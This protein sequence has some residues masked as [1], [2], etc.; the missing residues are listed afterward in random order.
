MS[1]A[2]EGRRAW[3]VHQNR[4]GLVKTT[5][6]GLGQAARADEKMCVLRQRGD[7][8]DRVA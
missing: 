8:F 3:E 2:V 5:L 7:F 4:E 6:H 1:G